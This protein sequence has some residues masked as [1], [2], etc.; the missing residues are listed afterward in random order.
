ML[1][2]TPPHLLVFGPCLVWLK[3]VQTPG[4]RRSASAFSLSILLSLSL[5]IYLLKAIISTTSHKHQIFI[6]IIV[7]KCKLCSLYLEFRFITFHN[8]VSEKLKKRF[9]YKNR[10]NLRFE[11]HHTLI[12]NYVSTPPPPH[13]ETGLRTDS[14][15]ETRPRWPLFLLLPVWKTWRTSKMG[16][17]IQ[18]QID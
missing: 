3:P 18:A 11:K 4:H 13:G 6:I 7:F 1:P 16:P 10:N 12:H 14:S 5:S 2:P 15:L 9:V 8:L 17:I